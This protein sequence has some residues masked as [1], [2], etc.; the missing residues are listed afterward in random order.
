LFLAAAVV[1]GP[2][3]SMA[4]AGVHIEINKH[5]AVT[6]CGSILDQET[7][8]EWTP[9]LG[10]DKL[11]MPLIKYT[12]AV[13][14]LQDKGQL[15]DEAAYNSQVTDGLLRKRELEVITQSTAKSVVTQLD[16]CE[17]SDWRLPTVAEAGSLFEKKRRTSCVGLHCG[18]R[19]LRFGG[20]RVDPAFRMGGCCAWTS[21]F[22]I[23]DSTAEPLS[24]S[25]GR[26]GRV[27]TPNNPGSFTDRRVLAVRVYD[28]K[29]YEKWNQRN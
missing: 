28:V 22:E 25:F 17:N 21:E 12:E 5:Y 15:E 1:F 13:E 11:Y 24:F 8:M 10:G 2:E 19:S 20:Y 18:P 29:K 16:F 3:I 26:D 23:V 6:D 14:K 7:G 9:D 27:T 4:G